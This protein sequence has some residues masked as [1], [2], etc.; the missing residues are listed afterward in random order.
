[1]RLCF[2]L[3]FT[4]MKINWDDARRVHFNSQILNKK[5][6]NPKNGFVMHEATS[7]SGKVSRAG[8]IDGWCFWTSGH[9]IE[10]TRRS[11]SNLR[12][13]AAHQP[14]PV[15]RSRRHKELRRA[16]IFEGLSSKIRAA[17]LR[18]LRFT[19]GER[20]EN[21]SATKHLWLRFRDPLNRAKAKYSNKKLLRKAS[22]FFFF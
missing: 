21:Q 17:R 5:K 16:A 15:F 14:K 7:R 2:I 20:R 11:A 1:M 18:C 8:T 12:Q 10:Q 19:R 4:E 3:N 9:H 22:L 13:V 6:K